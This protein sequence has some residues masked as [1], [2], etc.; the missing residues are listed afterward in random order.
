ME[1]SFFKETRKGDY[2]RENFDKFLKHLNFSFNIPSIHITGTNGKGS[3]VNFL[4][5]V[6]QNEGYKVGTFS[7][8][9][10]YEINE[11]ISINSNQ[12]SDDD[13][14]SIYKEYEREILKANL[15]YFEIE[16]FIA[17]KYFERKKCDVCIIECGMGGID[18]ATNIFTPILSIISTVSLEHTNFLG[19]TYATIAYSKAGIIKD[20]VP[21]VIGFLNDESSDVIKEVCSR[22]KSK[23]FEMA[24][25]CNIVV[26][27]DHSIFT[28][29]NYENVRI[30]SPCTFMIK[31]A[32][33]ALEAIEEI[34]PYF[35]LDHDKIISSFLVD[36]LPGRYNIL[37][38]KKNIIVDGAHN[39]Q[40]MTALKENVDFYAQNKPIHIIFASF[41]DKNLASM[42]AQIGELTKD[43]VFTTFPNPRARTEDEYFLYLEDYKFNENPIDIFNHFFEMYP[44]DIILV[45]GSLAFA[46]YMLKRIKV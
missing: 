43:I 6:F 29:R 9:Y 30:N 10:F 45:T 24:D 46:G 40:A 15:S 33:I 14:K 20:N 42:L 44:D 28:Y 27:N 39:P 13:I 38:E 4:R 34:L 18:D 35:K 8:P 1:E 41:R 2:Q 7:S 5:S 11:M 22:K 3:I 21:C 17:F 23:L 36:N 25:P 16:T 32:C 37:G 26:E 19:K 31:N 12:I